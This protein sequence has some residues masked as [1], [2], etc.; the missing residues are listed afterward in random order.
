VGAKQRVRAAFRS[1]VFRR[2]GYRCAV[3]GRPG[4]D[5]QGG[6]GHRPH[7]RGV[8]D[9]A[10]VPL[11]AHHITDRREMPGGGYVP[12]NGISLCD[13]G[14]HAL[15][16]ARHRTGTP[17]PGF[18]PDDLYAKIGSSFEEAYRASLTLA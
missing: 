12:E 17:H 1:A 15:A 10:L 14:C 7:H 6:D 8:P 2:D 18:S 4:R 13:L 3:C 16:E 11:D 5:R 9:E